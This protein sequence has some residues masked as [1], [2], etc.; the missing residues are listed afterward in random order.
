MSCIPNH[1]VRARI[2]L[3]TERWSDLTVRKTLT[4]GFSKVDLLASK[5]STFHVSAHFKLG[6]Q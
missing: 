5:G 1:W 6:S 4:A 3:H 2:S